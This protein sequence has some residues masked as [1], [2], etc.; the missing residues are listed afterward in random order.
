[1]KRFGTF[2]GVFVPSLLSILGVIM[3]LRLGWVVGQ[4]GLIA[5]IF[6]ILL[7]N[8]ISLSTAL[9]ISSIVTNIRIG[10]GGVYSIITKS[11]GIEAGGAIG[12]PLYLSQA[13]SVAFY[14]SGFSEMWV[15][16]FPSHNFLLVSLVAWAVIWLISSYSAKL[17]FRI[18]FVILTFIILSLISIF[19]AKGEP[20]KQMVL[21]QPF[22]VGRFLHTFAVFFPAVTG[23]LAGVSM[24][25]ELKDP[26]RNIPVGTLLAVGVSMLI[27]LVLAVWFS[28]HAS[29]E[30][31]INNT[32][33]VIQ[34]GRWRWLV[35]GGIMGATLSSALNMFVTAPRTLLALGRNAIIPFSSAFE[36]VNKKGEPQVAIL[37]TAFIALLTLKGGSLNSV[38]V[39]LTMFFL[40]T[41]ATLNLTVFIEQA[42][43]IPSFRPSFRIP[44]SVSFIGS[45][46]CLVVMFMINSFFTFVA[47][48]TILLIY[49]VLIQRHTKIYSP[50]IR[51]GLLIFMAE[52]LAKT[53]A[54]LPYYPK[55]WKP[56]LF[57]P[58]N[59]ADLLKAGLP[60]I[61]DIVYPSGRVF[62]CAV[63]QSPISERMFFPRRSNQLIHTKENDFLADIGKEVKAL[64][65][66][67]IFVEFAGIKAPDFPAAAMMALETVEGTHFPPNTVFYILDP[68]KNNG[69][70]HAIQILTQ[71]CRE[72]LGVIIF[73]PHPTK[74]LDEK[75][76]INLWIRQHSP[77]A[78][79]SILVALQLEKNWEG[80]VRLIQV[81]D[82][83]EKEAE[84][85]EYLLR[86]KSVVRLPGDVSIE[87][88]SGHF[89]EV[90]PQAPQADLNIF[91]MPLMPNLPF[92]R[93]I[94]S[95]IETPVLFLRDSKYE[96]STA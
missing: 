61:E 51:S 30:E 72:G 8:I 25:G 7:A 50:D 94:S 59:N 58:I 88:M 49:I 70:S 40:I 67:K 44:K 95:L 26:K 45:I 37:L 75:K 60:L 89:E 31:L 47:L 17:A 10:Y 82:E 35:I 27:Y 84:A 69:D 96:S 53:A 78:D 24:S 3:Y 93:R 21:W 18:Q 55:I 34:L 32:S 41:Y 73:L 56:N 39:L 4:V 71:V 6:I 46:G 43:G 57:V 83:K 13:I 48:S 63:A 29:A 80:R 20:V 5:A 19:S 81:V 77:N 38:A 42:I 1:M 85:R 14:I 92:I 62:I 87:V 15:S 22:E 65:E 11:L 74:H 76:M 28:S 52:H 68:E 12:I 33:I 91:G 79:L 66:K 64:E 86:L 90:I 16:I 9:S 36:R 54:R 23:V 2:E